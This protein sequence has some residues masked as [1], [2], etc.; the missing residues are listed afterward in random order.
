MNLEENI[1]EAWDF[2]FNRLFHQKTKLIYEYI[3][4]GGADGAFK[5]LP[6]KEEIERHYPNP[7]G[8]YTGM[9]DGD[10]N[11]GIMM[12]AVLKRYAVTKDGNMKKYADDLYEGMILNATLSK[13]KGFL[14]RS[15]LPEDGTSHYINSSRDQYTH[16]I[17]SMTH[18]YF[19]ELSDE[20]QREAIKNALAEF[21]KKAER[22]VKKENSYCLLDELG[23]PALVCRMYGEVYKDDIMWHETCRLPMFYMAAYVTSNDT[24]WLE[25]YRSVRDWGLTTAEDIKIEPRYYEGVFALMQMQISVRFLY[26]YE[27]EKE[28]KERYAALMQKVAS[29][30]DWYLDETKGFFKAYVMPTTVTP[31]REISEEFV[32]EKPWSLVGRKVLMPH[33]WQ[34]S[35]IDGVRKKLRNSSESIITQA[36]CPNGEISQSQLE[37]FLDVVSNVSFQSP[38]GYIATGYC[39]AWWTLKELGRV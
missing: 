35:S 26:D 38:F 27:T 24:Y 29:S 15:R 31:W 3:T 12:E 8:W 28:Y 36:L 18:F 10:I 37:A 39:L 11:G 30:I 4:D 17:E 2:V 19:S 20:S 5:H 14:I 33:I 9:E 22:D 34:A 21:A 7:C 25:K 1:Q 13:E 23:A 6:T 32:F 16:W